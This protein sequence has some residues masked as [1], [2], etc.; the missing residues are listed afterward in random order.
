MEKMGTSSYSPPID[1][2]LTYGKPEIGDVPDWPDYLALGLGPQH[3]PDLIRMV[4]DTTLLAPDRE[5]LAGWAPIHAWR[6]LGELRAEA[7]A[8][9]EHLLS[10]FDIDDD[11]DWALEELPA[12]YALIGPAALPALNAYIADPLHNHWGRITA[13]EAVQKIATNSPET[14]PVA[15]TLLMEQMERMEHLPTFEEND[16]DLN[17]WFVSALTQLKAQEALPLIERAFATGSVD[18][19]AAGDW[20]FVQSKFGLIT[21]EEAELRRAARRRPPSPLD[22]R[23]DRN[24]QY[25]RSA[26]KSHKKPGSQKKIRRTITQQSKKKN[27]KR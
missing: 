4:T 11:N 1:Q 6:A 9:A 21:E 3:V 18:Y 25:L 20:E 12:V 17:G 15:V 7:M 8:A 23:R 27:R 2:L 14:R 5:D 24:T 22:F 10:V 26:S 19:M 13:V 16:Y